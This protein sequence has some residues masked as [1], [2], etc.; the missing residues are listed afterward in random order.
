M[1]IVLARNWWALVL[2]GLFAVLFGIIALA[3]PGITLGALVLLYGAYALADG[4]FAIASVMAGRTWGR[5]W[6]SLLV[7]GL[8][9]IAVGIMTFAWPGITALVLLY[10]IAAWAFVTGIFE[11]V[12]AIRL[13]EEIRGEWL[14]A[15]SGILSVLFGVA[16][17]IWPGAGALALIWVIGAYAIAFGVL[18]IALGFRLRSWSRRESI[19]ATSPSSDPTTAAAHRAANA[20]R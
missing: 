10:L 20:A 6:W 3:W 5:P 18:M 14:L 2:R 17:V 4:V 13:R 19:R 1:V 15:L 9:G 11:I 12:A 7:E 8:V 16:L